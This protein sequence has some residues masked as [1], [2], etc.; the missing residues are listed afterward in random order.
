MSTY[1]D[2]RNPRR[3]WLRARQPA[4]EGT[5]YYSFR[6]AA[7]SA[8]S[9]STGVNP[10]GYADGSIDK[11]QHTWLTSLLAASTDKY[12]FVFSHH[13]SKTMTN[14]LVLTGLD[15]NPRVLGDE[16]V[17]SGFWPARTS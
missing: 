6:P 11:P 2:R 10:N 14:P 3:T 17:A 4:A 9:C 13:T 12:V 16:V 8:A 5:A 1:E 7:G 15:L